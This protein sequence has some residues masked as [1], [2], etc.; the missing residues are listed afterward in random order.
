[1]RIKQYY[2]KRYYCAY[3]RFGTR[4]VGHQTVGVSDKN[5]NSFIRMTT[6]SKM[7]FEDILSIWV[8]YDLSISIC[9]Y[10]RRYVT[11]GNKITL[12]FIIVTVTSIYKWLIVPESHLL[13]II[14]QLIFYNFCIHLIY[15]TGWKFCLSKLYLTII[16][17]TKKV[18]FFD[19]NFSICILQ[20][21]FFY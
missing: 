2:R 8:K 4:K 10:Q 20:K 6:I 5:K 19:G 9:D 21:H 7:S 16:T 3:C 18:W 15:C 11:V 13:G 12:L 1:M 17:I 14:F